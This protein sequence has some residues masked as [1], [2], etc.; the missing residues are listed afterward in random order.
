MQKLR[1][2]TAV[3]SIKFLKNAIELAASLKDWTQMAIMIGRNWETSGAPPL[4]D[5]R[6][7]QDVKQDSGVCIYLL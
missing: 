1:A 4:K 7:A 2:A 3:I 6:D 5:L